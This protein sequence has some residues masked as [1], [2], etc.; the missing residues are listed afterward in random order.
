MSGSGSVKGKAAFHDVDDYERL[1][2]VARAIDR[3]TLLIRLLGGDAGLRC[4]EMIALEWCDVDLAKR[5]L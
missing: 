3:R 1:V 5:Q 2:D 4:G